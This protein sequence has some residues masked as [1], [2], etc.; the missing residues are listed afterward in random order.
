LVGEEQW[1]D[2]DGCLE[3]IVAQEQIH[4]TDTEQC[5]GGGTTV[6]GAAFEVGHQTCDASFWQSYCEWAALLGEM[7]QT[8]G[9]G[10]H[11]AGGAQ[12]AIAPQYFC[13]KLGAGDGWRGYL[14]FILV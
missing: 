1:W 11:A 10:G 8:A 13:D 3:R 2:D 6:W 5:G 9:E 4:N 12:S 7:E 14:C